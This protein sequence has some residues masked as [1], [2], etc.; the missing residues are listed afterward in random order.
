MISSS[1]WMS[2]LSTLYSEKCDYIASGT[3]H[4]SCDVGVKKSM[5]FIQFVWYD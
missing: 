1:V 2:M 4:K 3:T 5:C